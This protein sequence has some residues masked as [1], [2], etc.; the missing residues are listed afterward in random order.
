MESRVPLGRG[1]GGGEVEW[2]SLYVEN[3]IRCG[4]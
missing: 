1:G 3:H 4:F 2:E